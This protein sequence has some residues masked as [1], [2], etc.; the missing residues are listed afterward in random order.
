MVSMYPGYLV[1]EVWGCNPGVDTFDF[2]I[3]V[4]DGIEILIIWVH[5]W[6]KGNMVSHHLC[7]LGTILDQG[8]CGESFQHRARAQ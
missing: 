3:H 4:P 7:N 1:L 5:G 2:F 8:V 6:L